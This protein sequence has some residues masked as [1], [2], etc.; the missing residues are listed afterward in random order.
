MYGRTR[1]CNLSGASGK[2]MASLIISP[3]LQ[4]REIGSSSKFTGITPGL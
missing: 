4:H 2:K 3:C 1:V